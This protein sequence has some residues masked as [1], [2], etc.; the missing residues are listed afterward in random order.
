MARATG[1][2]ERKKARTRQHIAD[3]A[4][5]LFATH[6]F[7]QV[8]IVEVAQVAEVSEQTVYN[9]FPAKHD[10]VL[11]RAEEIRE[12]YASTVV[13]RPSNTSPAA[14]L[15]PEARQDIERYRHADLDLARGEAPALCVR[16]PS[17]RRFVLEARDQ[18]VETVTAAVIETCPTLHP[19]VAR[20]HVAAIISVFQMIGDHIGRSVLDGAPQEAV[21][22]ELA[23]TVEV[24]FDDLDQHFRSLTAPTPPAGGRST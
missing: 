17:L 5:R 24:V 12:R 15:R 1:L 23:A 11:D 13:H 7:D 3:V 20:A 16:H 19:G 9:Y 21:A 18:Q 2:R 22:D 10:L 14:A 4:A 6:G 8:S